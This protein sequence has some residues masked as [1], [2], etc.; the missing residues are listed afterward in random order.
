MR[1][2]LQTSIIHGPRPDL[3]PVDGI[4]LNATDLRD[5]GPDVLVDIRVDSD[6]LDWGV[7]DTVEVGRAKK[8]EPG[9]EREGREEGGREGGRE[10]GKE[11][12]RERERER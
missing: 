1:N 12:E 2:R 8:R 11:R 9:K 3:A 5:G 6:T 4:L 10:G 7:V